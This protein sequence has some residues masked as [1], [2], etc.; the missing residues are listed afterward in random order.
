MCFRVVATELCVNLGQYRPWKFGLLSPKWIHNISLLFLLKLRAWMNFSKA[1]CNCILI[2][3][4]KAVHLS[5]HNTVSSH[6]RVVILS[7]FRKVLQ[8]KEL[9]EVCRDVVNSVCAVRGFVFGRLNSEPPICE[10]V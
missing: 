4:I 3:H 8:R 7:V 5:V 6:F 9:K 2:C 10:F 1:F